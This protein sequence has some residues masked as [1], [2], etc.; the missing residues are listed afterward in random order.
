MSINA[1]ISDPVTS[2]IAGDAIESSGHAEK[3]R[4]LALAAVQ[5]FPGLTATELEDKTGLDRY[6][7]CRRLPELRDDMFVR[8][9][10]GRKCG[11][12]GRL[13]QTWYPNDELLF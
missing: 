10:N 6:M 2:H 7:L 1:R 8:N 12:A 9:G 4:L 11:V 5:E 13:M 3:Q